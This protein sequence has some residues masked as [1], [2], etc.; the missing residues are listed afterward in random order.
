M[1]NFSA[2]IPDAVDV[3]IVGAGIVGGACFHALSTAGRGLRVACFESSA[4]LS[5]STAR[6]AAAFRHQFSAAVNVQMSIF[7]SRVYEEFPVRMGTGPV[8]RRNGYCFV[9]RSE[10]ALEAAAARA[11]RQRALGVPDVEVLDRAALL[12]RFPVLEPRGLAGG[13]FCRHDG[14]VLP[15]A[16]TNAYFDRGLEIGGCLRQYAPVV[17]FVSEGGRLRGVRVRRAGEPEREVRAPVVVNAAGPWSNAV[18]RLA[19]LEIPMVPVKRYL[20]FT[21]QFDRRDVRD[22]PLFVV[23]LEAYCRPEANGLM[24]GWD[25]RPEKPEGWRRFPPPPFDYAAMDPDRIEAGFG[26]GPDDYGTEVLAELASVLPFLAEEAGLASVTAGYYEV[27]PDEKAIVGWDPRLPGL[28]HAT[29]FS[30]HGVMHAPATAAIVRALVLGEP[31]PVDPRPLA[32][33]PLLRNEPREDPE[34]VVI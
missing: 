16:I 3:V 5:G 14:F 20:Y 29:G 22:L 30:G 1:G 15:D 13:T 27:S 19:G 24:M 33:E 6:S 9:Y 2:P 8:I 26:I 7:A 21:Q 32:L 23:D 11:A 31:P 25:R 17:G 4:K 12:E 10:D 34:E 28:L 18:S